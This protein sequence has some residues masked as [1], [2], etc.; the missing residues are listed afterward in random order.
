M[1]LDLS[2]LAPPLR[3]SSQPHPSASPLSSAS[4]LQVPEQ[5]PPISGGP[6]STPSCGSSH[7][8]TSIGTRG[9]FPGVA[10]SRAFWTWSGSGSQMAVGRWCTSRSCEKM[11][12]SPRQSTQQVCSARVEL[13]HKTSPNP[14]RPPPA[15]TPLSPNLWPNPRPNAAV[16]QHSRKYVRLTY[17]ESRV[18]TWDG[19]AG[20]WDPPPYD[21]IAFPPSSYESAL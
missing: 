6:P 18:Y 20:S 8:V 2:G 10:S 1:G 11:E 7:Q 17:M 14:L 21:P 12:T 19:V 3:R 13:N 5:Q 9:A 4:E 15:P 16:P